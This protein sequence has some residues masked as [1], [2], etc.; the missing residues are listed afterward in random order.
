MAGIT[1]H[2]ARQ[3]VPIEIEIQAYSVTENGYGN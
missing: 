3:V 2:T 1:L